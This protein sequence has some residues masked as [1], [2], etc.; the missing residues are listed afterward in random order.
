MLVWNSVA[1]ITLKQD[2][3]QFEGENRSIEVEFMDKSFHRNLSI[4]D[5]INV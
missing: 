1:I 3:A 2:P 5:R 4:N